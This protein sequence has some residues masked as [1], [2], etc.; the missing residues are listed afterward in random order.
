MATDEWE[1]MGGSGLCGEWELTEKLGQAAANQA[2][3]KHW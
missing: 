1:S 3:Q 2:F